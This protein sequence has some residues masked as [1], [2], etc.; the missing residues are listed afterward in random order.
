MSSTLD[1]CGLISKDQIEF[2]R[3]PRTNATRLLTLRACWSD[4]ITL[5]Q[6]SYTEIDKRDAIDADTY[7]DAASLA[8]LAAAAGFSLSPC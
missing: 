6:I 8:I 1:G 7:F 4:L 2:V 5:R 3:I